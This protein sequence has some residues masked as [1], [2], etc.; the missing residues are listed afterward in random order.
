MSAAMAGAAR[1][2]ERGGWLGAWASWLDIGYADG[3]A[4]PTEASAQQAAAEAPAWSRE[5]PLLA[6]DGVTLEYSTERLRVRATERVSLQV[7]EGERYVL[8]GPS[9]CGK[10]TLLKAVAGFVA[11]RE[12]HIRL[13]GEALQ[14]PGPD[15][16]VVF[17][18]FDQLP[19]WKTVLDNVAFPLRT[20]KGWSRTAAHERAREVLA[21][22][23]LAEFAA[24]YPHQLSG[25]MKQRVV[26]IIST[27][28]NPRLLIADEPTSALD[29]SS[30]KALIEMLL[31]MLDKR[32]MSGV[33]FIT[34]DLPALRTVAT[35]IGVMYQGRMVETGPTDVIVDNPEHPYTQALLS[36][37]LTPEPKYAKIRIE[38]MSSY[39]RSLFDAPE[40]KH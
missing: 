13:A 11:P 12:G 8:L 17:Q 18:E 39:D 4:M 40:V 29:V 2:R 5:Q 9:G 20:A 23:G 24:A 34:H 16:I 36:S 7:H 32:I 19:P 25:G 35:H 28:L 38:G 26:T 30:Q 37:V 6:L 31:E 1:E 14:G 3:L 10:S 21:Q 15:R 22:V 27:L 33:I